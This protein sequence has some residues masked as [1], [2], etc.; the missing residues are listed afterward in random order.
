MID[1]AG[2]QTISI[3][4]PH[5]THADVI[6]RAAAKGV[7][8][9]WWRSRSPPTWRTP[10]APSTPR[11]PPASSWAWS[12]SAASTRPWRAWPSAIADGKIGRPILGTLVVM[13]WR[14]EA[15]YQS[16]AVARQLERRGRRRARQPDAAPAGHAAVADGLAHR[17]ALRL[18]GQLQPP[19]CRDRRHCRR[20]AALQERRHRADPGQQLAEAG[21]VRQDARPRLQRRFG[22]RADGRRL[23]LRRRRDHGGGAADQRHLE[24]ARRGGYARRV[25][26]RGPRRRPGTS[27]P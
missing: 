14:D 26:G 22:R 15:Y 2:V 5:P 16:D 20:G 4:T 9:R 18:L 11:A 3:C 10:T 21:P 13:G 12:A 6:V 8:T 1:D 7:S 23:A 27:T 19:V 25:A 24:R 17:R